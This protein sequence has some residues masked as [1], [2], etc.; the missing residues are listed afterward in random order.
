MNLDQLGIATQTSFSP[1]HPIHGQTQIVITGHTPDSDEF[2]RVNRKYN[3]PPKT[4]TVR[5]GKRGGASAEIPRDPNASDKRKKILAAIVTNIT[6]IDGWEYSADAAQEL[7][8]RDDCAW[9]V[10]QWEEHLDDRGNFLAPSAPSAKRGSK[11][12]AG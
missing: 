8:L 5:Y 2:E 12:T 3:P 1:V 11:S 7:F 9:L 10:E 6:G 4:Q